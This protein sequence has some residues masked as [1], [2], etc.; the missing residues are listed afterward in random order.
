MHRTLQTVS[1]IESNSKCKI[2]LSSRKSDFLAFQNSVLPQSIVWI[3]LNSYNSFVAIFV[4]VCLLGHVTSSLRS[5]N[6]P[7]AVVLQ[8]HPCI[9]IT[10]FIK[11]QFESAFSIFHMSIC[12]LDAFCLNLQKFVINK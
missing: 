6:I 12:V 3:L 5:C 11:L 8:H 7:A 9:A 4:E 1:S 2:N 10:P